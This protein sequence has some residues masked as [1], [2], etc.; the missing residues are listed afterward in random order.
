MEKRSVRVKLE[1]RFLPLPL[2]L[3]AMLQLILPYQGWVMLLVGLGGVWLLAF[4]WAHALARGLRVV[5][6]MRFGWAQVGDRLEERFTLINTSLVPALWVELLDHSTLPGYTASRVTGI[7]G[8]S[9]NRWIVKGACT[10]RGVYALGPTTLRTGDPFGL[11]TVTLHRPA[12]TTMVVMPPIVP[13]PSIEVAPGGRAGEGR[14]RAPVFERTVSASSVREYRP[15]DALHSIHWRVSAHRDD[16]FV[17]RFDHMP[18]SDW[19]ICLDLDR[20]VQAG[21]GENSTLEHGIILAASLADRGSRQ[22]R[23]VGLV[24]CGAEFV[25]LPPQSGEA[26]RWEILRALALASPGASSLSE[27]LARMQPAFYRRTSLVVITPAAQGDWIARLVPLR[28]RGVVPTV[29]LL[30]PLSFGDT[31]DAQ[32]ALATLA[33][34]EIPRYLIP[35][36]M[37][38]RAETR[39]GQRG[40]WDWQVTPSGRAILKGKMREATWKVLA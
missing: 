3:L 12:W 28:W 5:R 39:P 19:W 15:G 17:R 31:R 8:Q 24:A 20:R 6:E 13:L 29:L 22:G 23:A 36:Q 14:Q 7:E 10:R 38:D 30:D 21:E 40:H 16:W 11:Y 25:W 34:L 26:R 2:L 1:A 32:N 35:R 9:E 27:L 18:S 4:V 37:L 33:A